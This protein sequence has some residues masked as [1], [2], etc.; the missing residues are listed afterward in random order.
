MN[1]FLK[2]IKFLLQIVGVCVIMAMLNYIYARTM[3]FLQLCLE[4]GV[5]SACFWRDAP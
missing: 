1:K 4:V 3:P 5:R 2:N